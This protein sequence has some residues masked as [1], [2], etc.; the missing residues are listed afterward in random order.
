MVLGYRLFVRGIYPCG[1]RESSID[2]KAAGTGFTLKNAAPGSGFGIFG[3]VLI[4]VMLIQ[5]NPQFTYEMMQKAA[6]GGDDAATTSAEAGDAGHRRAGCV[7]RTGGEGD[8]IRAV[9]RSGA[10]GGGLPPGPRRPCG[11]HESAC[12]AL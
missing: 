3:V 8:G 4:T 12:V 1:D 9:G 11:A 10:C 6:G 7:R 2:F 5:G